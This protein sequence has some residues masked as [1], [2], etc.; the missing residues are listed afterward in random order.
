MAWDFETDPDFQAQLD[1]VDVFVRE[2]VE[3]LD[4]VLGSPYDKSDAKAMAVL[5]PLQQKVKDRKL[6]AAHLGPDLGGQG[7]GQVKLALLNEILGRSGWAA[8]VFG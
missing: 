1:W 6:W 5:K 7:Y 4:Y 3:P 2:E 8:S